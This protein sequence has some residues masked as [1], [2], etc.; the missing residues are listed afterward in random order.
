MTDIGFQVPAVGNCVLDSM[1]LWVPWV[2]DLNS[3][4][5]R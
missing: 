5:K 4:E 3:K 1:H 2:Q